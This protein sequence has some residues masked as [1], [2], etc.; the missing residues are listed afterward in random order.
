MLCYVMLCYVMLCYAMLCH[1]MSC[2]V[3]LCYVM[4]CY[5][6]LSYVM[7]CYVMSCYVMLCC[8]NYERGRRK[9]GKTSVIQ[10]RGAAI[11]RSKIIREL[12]TGAMNLA[13]PHPQT[14]HHIN[15][16][17]MIPLYKR[18]MLIEASPA[19]IVCY[20]NINFVL[21]HTM[22]QGCIL[23]QQTHLGT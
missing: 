18:R 22:F 1:V 5:V 21:F 17:L 20:R 13:S 4:L 16:L 8:Y 15:A 19:Y 9:R 6:M 11:G 14:C 2:H 7:L 3:M 23:F 10:P 12:D